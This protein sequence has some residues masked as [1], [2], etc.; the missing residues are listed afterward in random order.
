MARFAPLSLTLVACAAL[1]ACDSAPGICLVTPDSSV[2]TR[3]IRPATGDT[4]RLG[5]PFHLF[6]EFSGEGDVPEVGVRVLWAPPGRTGEAPD[7]ILFELPLAAD[8]GGIET[9]AV[10][11]MLTVDS[12]RGGAPSDFD[13]DGQF[14][15]SA[16]GR[17]RYSDCGG[18]G[19]ESVEALA[20][21]TILD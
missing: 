4:L 14:Y 17:A 13:P 11:R 7:S 5:E 6:A 2:S 12:L 16:Y 3:L 8:I 20:A 15:V 19:G 9:V 10:E 1:A 18:I 21:V